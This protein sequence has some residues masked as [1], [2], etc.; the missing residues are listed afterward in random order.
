MQSDIYFGTSD[1]VLGRSDMSFGITYR[2]TCR[3]VVM[4]VLDRLE[5]ERVLRDVDFE[6]LRAGS[7][8]LKCS[9]RLAGEASRT[10]RQDEC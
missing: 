6:C 5:G 9:V 1:L 10:R 3:D 2:D 8:I 4:V 7:L